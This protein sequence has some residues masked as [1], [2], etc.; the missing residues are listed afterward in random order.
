MTKGKIIH[1]EVA[2]NHIVKIFS[3]KY[4]IHQEENIY[5]HIDYYLFILVS[6]I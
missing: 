5:I 2:V 3:I 6:Y 4:L 1:Y